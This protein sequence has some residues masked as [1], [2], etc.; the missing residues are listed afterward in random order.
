M[1]NGEASDRPRSRRGFTLIELL[2]VLAIIALLLS[3]V[4]PRYLRSVGHAEET[5]LR[6]NLWL[7]RDAIDKHYADVGSYPQSLEEL[8]ARRYLRSIPADPMTQSPAS[9]VSVAPS[10]A[11]MTGVYDVRSGATGADRHGVPYA[12]W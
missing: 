3:I 8:V 1:R 5:V 6:E 4:S 12:Q 10:E 7:L 11:G 9:W 2:V